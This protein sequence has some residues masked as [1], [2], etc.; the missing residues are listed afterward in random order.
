LK[1]NQARVAVAS[2]SFSSNPI[3]REELL[4]RYENVTFNDEGLRLSG[5]S[6]IEFL[7][8][9]E[10]AITA[11]EVVDKTIVASLPELKVLSKYGVGIDMI[12]VDA[13]KAA[14]IGFG[15]TKGVNRRSV[16]E[17]VIAA[18]ISLLH[19]VPA[20]VA[21]VR[22]G[23][24]RQLNGSQLSEKT[25]G[26]VGCGHVGRD[27]IELL[28][29]FGCRVVFNDILDMTEFARAHGCAQV[30]LA[31]LLQTSDVVTLHTPLDESTRSLI[32]SGQLRLM[33]PHAILI[34][35]ARGGIVDEIAL[36]NA[37]NAEQL[38][39]AALDVLETEPPDPTMSNPLF[40]HPQVVVTPHIGGSAKE[41]VLAMGRAAIAGLDDY[42]V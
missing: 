25:V 17:L 13:L 36:L 41:A 10:K 6:L 28:K 2:R 18:A 23:T 37:L 32:G 22:A 24:W 7:K 21:E 12:D 26:I 38:A 29:P 31:T 16:A 33:Q 42:V 11:L 40:H 35:M 3:L 15:W 5:V 34:N 39:G 4:L 19:R 14:G 30:D 20:A 8:G 27:V 9:H 1:K